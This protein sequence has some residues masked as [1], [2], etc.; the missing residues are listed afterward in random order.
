MI[1]HRWF[2]AIVSGIGFVAV[3]YMALDLSG[4]RR[5]V[6]RVRHEIAE[7]ITTVDHRIRTVEEFVEDYR[8]AA[9]H[10]WEWEKLQT[11]ARSR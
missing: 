10:K 5:D 9:S 7:A 11:E 4:L 3:I 2:V 1:A 8:K 6:L